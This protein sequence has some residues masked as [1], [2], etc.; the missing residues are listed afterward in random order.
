MALSLM[1]KKAVVE[2]VAEIARTAH[3]VVAADYRGSSVAQMTSL[4]EKA[5]QSRVYL[6]V[7]RN[8]LARR[9]IE[10]TDFEC[11]GGRLVGPLVLA[12]SRDEPA[13][14]A[15]VVRDCA[16]ENDRLI[17]RF[18]AFDGTIIDA[19][20]IESLASLPTREELLGRFLG[21]LT[22]PVS[23]FVRTLAEPPARVVRTVDAMRKSQAEG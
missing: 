7:V 18:A 11:M 15:R 23:A 17:I 6:R 20:D 10:G 4:R 22:A 1:Q 13:A 5:K 14:A 12:F 2:E 16:K 9:A 3:S 19:S 21:L 8:T